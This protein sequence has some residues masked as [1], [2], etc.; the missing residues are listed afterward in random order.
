MYQVE[1]R[2]VKRSYYLRLGDKVSVVTKNAM[3]A[4]SLPCMHVPDDVLEMV[5]LPFTWHM[6]ALMTFSYPQGLS[7]ASAARR[8]TS[9]RSSMS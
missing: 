1:L 9:I 8:N 7:A 3:P 5:E 2:F 4:H 6:S